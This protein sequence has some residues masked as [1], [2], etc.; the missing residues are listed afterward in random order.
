VPA[1]CFF[2]FRYIY[3]QFLATDHALETSLQQQCYAVCDTRTV[4]WRSDRSVPGV[5]EGY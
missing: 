4:M 2:I 1:L 5:S 3:I